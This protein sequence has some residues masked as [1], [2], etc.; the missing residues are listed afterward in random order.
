MNYR[1]KNVEKKL[2]HKL[3]KTCSKFLSCVIAVT[4]GRKSEHKPEAIQRI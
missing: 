2:Y 4:I 3:H 1:R